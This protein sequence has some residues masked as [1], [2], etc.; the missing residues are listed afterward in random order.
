MDNFKENL[1]VVLKRVRRV[2]PVLLVGSIIVTL[3]AGFTY[4]ITVDD[5]LYKED[6]W[7][8]TPYAAST[9]TNSATINEDGTIGFSTTAEELWN[10]MLENGSR[11]DEYLDS[12]EELARLMKAEL[13]TQFPDTRSNPDE[14]IDWDSIING[15][16]LQGIIKFI[17]ADSEGNRSTMT[18][19]D[20]ATFQSYVDEYNK[21]GS[22]TAKQNALSHFTLK[23]GS[24]SS[25]GGA[26]NYNGPDLCWPT[27]STTITS[28]FGPRNSPTAGASSN[29]QGIDI[30][31]PEGSDVYACE[32][33]TV[34]TAT[35]DSSAGNFVEV[36]HGNG[37]VSR[38]LHNSSFNVSVGEQVKK[39]QVIA[40][41]GNTGT[42][43]GPHCHFEIRVNGTAIDP[44]SFKYNNGM[45]NGTGGFGMDDDEDE[46]E[47]DENTE[48]TNTSSSNLAQETP[49][50]GDGYDMEYTSSSGITYKDFK[51]Y[52]GSY[53]NQT[54]WGG[55]ISSHGC[56]PTSMA[57]L[58]SGL[59]DLNYTPAD[60][61]R[62]MTERF[63]YE[64]VTSTPHMQEVL[65]SLGIPSEINQ[66]P[67]ADDI[68][69]ALK[70]GKVLMVSVGSGTI[71]T[72]NDHFIALV[73]INDQGQVYV[74]NPS[75]STESGWFDI[76]EIMKDCNSMQSIDSGS[77]GMATS[78]TSSNSSAYTAVVATWRQVDETIETNDP[79]VEGG[80]KPTIYT[81]T[82]TDI[83]Y[84]V[85]VEPYT[86]PFDFLWALLVVGED[87]NFAFDIADLAYNSQIEI[88]VHDN[89]T[90]NTDIDHWTYTQRTKAEVGKATI[91]AN[92]GGYT[93]S[94]SVE[95]HT[96]DPWGEDQNYTTTKTVVT[97][98][99][100]LNIALTRANVWIVDY[101]N[102]FTYS[103][104]TKT[105]TPGQIEMDDTE[106]EQTGTGSSFDC[107]HIQAKKNEL[108]STVRQRYSSAHTKTN[109]SNLA[110]T[111]T[112]TPPG[113]TFDVNVSVKYFTKYINILDTT[114]DI[115][116]IKKY[117]AGTPD[118]KEKTD[119]D[120]DEPNFV[121]IFNEPKYKTNKS[122]IKSA[123]EWLFEILET[124][125][126]T[127]D[128]VDLM[129]YLLY[130]ATGVNYGVTEFD[131][132]IFYPGSLTSVGA[133]DYIVHI[134][135]SPQEIVIK[136]VETLKTAFAGSGGAG[137]DNLV[138]YADDFLRL[139]EEYRVN[140][141]FAAAVTT[142][143][144]GAGTNLQI[145]GNNWFSIRNPN[146][147]WMQ[148]DSPAGSIEA[149]CNQ[150]ARLGYYFTEGNY[151]VR[152][153]GMIYCED[154][155]A[156]GGWIENVLMYMTNMF[157]AAGIDV[158][159]FIG[160]G[161]IVEIAK[162]CHD[163]VRTNGFTYL[164][165]SAHNTIPIDE[166]GYRTI[167]CS[168]FVT[169]VL[170]EYGYTDLGGRQQDTGTLLGLAQRKGWTIKDG[171]QAQAG[172]IML[173]PD[174]HT[175]IYAG[176]G[177]LYDCGSDRWIQD[178]I[179]PMNMNYTYAITVTKP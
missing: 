3:L 67:T 20:Q 138:K 31:V 84:E 178:V 1:K 47:T 38:Y 156:P 2:I 50:T 115:V 37:Y 95:A 5:G 137:S 96:H 94:G 139:Q 27:T 142:A 74:L 68:Q 158:S 88:T 172:D 147:G 152:S 61:A 77:T 63:G 179:T 13:V 110:S 168:S 17:R 145:G 72:D 155:D 83:N 125:D 73:D 22:P 108:A 59:T 91:V 129:K 62:L 14:E 175:S 41:S 103:E 78:G 53:A 136:D 32:D 86:M 154:A 71:F 100:T 163:Y 90:I 133:N 127:S 19:V 39:G 6:D 66:S 166:S 174:C 104:P 26:V 12:P 64:N 21:T 42:S 11:V 9:F 118:L 69:S 112:A 28:N 85:M 151:T 58:L 120:S 123:A 146:G 173:I 51:Q 126:S 128:M 48:D 135:K 148:Y 165:N 113:V 93:A 65:D 70:S 149:F 164:Q 45:G 177:Q 40:F 81:M 122:N 29:H 52:K 16:N 98:T 34:K 57:I 105:E 140:A 109:T 117:I 49:V 4:F 116:E 10:K 161:D 130:K 46:N 89:L 80:D 111:G 87:K 30:G 143:E 60:T 160:G 8:S 43:T 150:I 18:Y 107:T 25:S 44:L 132:T 124:N 144:C 169:W 176:N 171:S 75:D 121:T 99:N 24:S 76:G 56:G 79:N 102:E 54:Y 170:Y 92:C 157:T 106:Y 33:G 131:F 153:I 7:S 114:T 162:Q 167:D 82:T 55:T 159:Q 141:V 101:K 36:D 15:D 35:F 23:K 97:Q 134:D 119:P